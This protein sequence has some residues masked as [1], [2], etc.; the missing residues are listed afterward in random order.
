[1]RQI[2][3]KQIGIFSV[4]VVAPFNGASFFFDDPN[5]V[6]IFHSGE[7]EFRHDDFDGFLVLCGAELVDGGHQSLGFFFLGDRFPD[8]VKHA[9]QDA[10][11]VVVVG[12]RTFDVE[13]N[14][15]IQM[16]VRVVFFC[17]EGRSDFEH[18]FEASAH[19][20]LFEQLRRLIQVGW[21]L[22]VLHG[23]Q[24]GSTF[25][26]GGDD[27][28]GVGFD[29]ALGDQVFSAKL[30]DL[31][32]K[33]KHGVDMRSSQIQKSIV[34]PRVKFHVHRVGDAQW[35]RCFSTSND[36]DRHGDDFVSGRRG[37]F[38]VLHLGWSLESH[39]SFELK[40]GFSG[41]PLHSI[42]VLRTNVVGLEEDLGFSCAVAQVNKTDGAFPAI[43]FHEA[44]DGHLAVDQI[45]AMALNFAKS[46]RAV[47]GWNPRGHGSGT[48][49]PS[50]K[51]SPAFS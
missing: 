4:D 22:K 45:F 30:Q 37:W 48:E 47:G 1:M 38:A 20:Q 39:R 7:R 35:E 40:R 9:F 21:C 33:S 14:K 36:V 6:A 28:W 32:T 51:D 3:C 49:G 5:G 46:V 42:E 16:S 18:P 44:D 41:H 34:K 15:F 17:S 26:S 13:G 2:F 43:G 31:S 25:R 23:E 24:I 11:D 8:V 10:H 50:M 29:M 27:F 12:P 19:A